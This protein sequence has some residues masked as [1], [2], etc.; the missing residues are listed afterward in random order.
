[1][2]DGTGPTIISKYGI[3][4]ITKVGTGIY[5][6]NFISA[7][8]NTNYSVSGLTAGVNN[9]AMVIITATSSADNTNNNTVNGF[10][11]SVRGQ[12]GSVADSNYISLQVFQ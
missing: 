7:L 1:M 8:Q 10:T 2:F 4:S 5:T 3:S 12:N 11:V 9:G 6:I